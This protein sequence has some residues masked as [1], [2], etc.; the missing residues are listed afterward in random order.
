MVLKLRVLAGT[1]P[2]SMTPITSLVNTNKA[3]KLSSEL[4]EGEIVAHIKNFPGEDGL[5][6]ESEYF[7]REDRQGITWSIQVRGRFLVP[8]SADD[9][10]F[11]N[12]FDRPLKLPWGTGAVLKFMN[13]I[14]PTMEHDLQ[15]TSKPWALSPLVSTMP[16]LMH[17]RLDDHDPSSSMSDRSLKHQDRTPSFP[18][19]RS[20]KDWTPD[21]YQTLRERAQSP[22][23]ISSSS[24]SSSSS[25]S[26][27]VSFRSTKSNLSSLSASK[28]SDTLKDALKKVKPSSRDRKRSMQHS[29][30]EMR[31]DNAA[32]RRAFF[33]DAA[34]RQSVVFGPQDIITT[35]FC[36]GFIEFS[37]SLALRL[38][39]GLSFDLMRYWDGQ[40]VRFVCCKRKS[41]EDTGKD[42][43]GEPW[44]KIFWCIAIESYEDE[45]V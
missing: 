6:R 38:P 2:E 11:G 14:D 3:Q 44:E 43:D 37:P 30:E 23:S 45:D 13:Y 20:I 8:C 19:T 26:S 42:G 22:S 4:F 28:K 32:A 27:L 17:Q 29:P 39:G 36:Y 10:L 18:S 21:I 33:S 25:A 35:D 12:T 15:S 9:I 16:Y 40:P 1:S 31:F 5:V 41:H 7:S 24:T 34:N